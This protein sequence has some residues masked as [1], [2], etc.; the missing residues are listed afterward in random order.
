MYQDVKDLMYELADA[1]YGIDD[2]IFRVLFDQSQ[3]AGPEP[4]LPLN[5]HNGKCVLV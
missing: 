1:K 2:H 4:I 3:P 5:F